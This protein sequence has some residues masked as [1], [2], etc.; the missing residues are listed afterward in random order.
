MCAVPGWRAALIRARRRPRQ[1]G[2]PGF[3]PAHVLAHMAHLL[4]VAA[5]GLQVD[6]EVKH[7][8]VITPLCC[9]QQ[10]L[11]VEVVHERDVALT[12]MQAGVVDAHGLHGAHVVQG[13]RLIDVVLDAPPKLLVGA[14][15]Q[16][17]C[18]LDRQF[19]TQ[20]Q[21]ERLEQRGEA[22]AFA[23]PRHTGLTGLAAAGARHA[24]H[25]GVQ[26]G[27]ELAE[28]QMPPRAAQP[29]MDALVGRA[30][31]RAGKQLG[32]A[33]YLEGM[34]DGPIDDFESRSIANFDAA[35]SKFLRNALPQLDLR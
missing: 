21:R 16:R 5:V 31:V 6:R 12:A 23:R 3:R 34:I 20:C 18:L 15:Q 9:E 10:P 26:P 24:G 13:A 30:A 17:R 32:R 2:V 7:R 29:I 1:V 19:P 14:A 25:I 22:R 27:F 33:A 28:I 11:G 35:C 8:L 4:G